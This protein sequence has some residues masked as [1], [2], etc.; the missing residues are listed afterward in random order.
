MLSAIEKLT[1]RI[2]DIDRRV[3][4]QEQLS[5]S[6]SIHQ[7]PSTQS[8]PKPSSQSGKR[9]ASQSSSGAIPSP[10]RLQANDVIQAQVDNRMRQYQ[11]MSRGEESGMWVSKPLK[12]GRYR[13]GDQRVKVAVRWPHESVSLGE[14]F[15]MP[16]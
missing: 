4:R 2:E 8:S 6:I 9:R 16:S 15:R 5:S 3:E 10:D 11:N 7:G 14:N 1:E 12:S 13:L